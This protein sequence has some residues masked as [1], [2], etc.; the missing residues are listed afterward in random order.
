MAAVRK[1]IPA[2]PG[3]Q[4]RPGLAGMPQ[5]KSTHGTDRTAQGQGRSGR[6]H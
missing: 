3:I 2:T 1:H 4:N 6:R 5:F